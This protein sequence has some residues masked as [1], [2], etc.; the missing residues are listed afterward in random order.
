[1]SKRTSKKVAEQNTAA[2]ILVLCIAV[3]M[4]TFTVGALLLRPAKTVANFEQC[5]E[6]GGTIL[7]SY[8]ELCKLGDTTF[9]NDKQSVVDA[10]GYMGLSEKQ[11]LAKAKSESVAA[12]VVEREGEAL[13][14]TMDFS[15]GRHNLYIKEGNVYKVVIEG[16]ASD[17]PGR[18]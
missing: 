4:L 14:V 16:Q 6:E 7:E 10:D 9:T 2:I 3:A 13:P 5:K 15:F 18:Q 11:A 1:M 8:P 17:L 12:R